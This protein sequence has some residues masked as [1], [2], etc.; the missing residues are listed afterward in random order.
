MKSFSKSFV[1]IFVVAIMLVMAL[2]VFAAGIPTGN[3]QIVVKPGNGGTV[4][5]RELVAVQLMSYTKEGEGQ[6]SY[7][8]SDAQAAVLK[9]AMKATTITEINTIADDADKATVLATLADWMTPQPPKTAP[10]SADISIL[11]TKVLAD[12]AGVATLPQRTLTVDG[13]NQKIENV[14]S[15][16]YIIWDKTSKDKFTPVSFVLHSEETKEVTV[17]GSDD[18]G[19][20]LK[21][22]VVSVAGTAGE[23]TVSGGETV[24]FKITATLPDT[25]PYKTY[26]FNILDQMG[27]GLTL[28]KGSIVVKVKGDTLT[29]NDNA[30][31]D[32]TKEYKVTYDVEKTIA[33]GAQKMTFVVEL[34]NATQYGK[35]GEV[36]VTYSAT[37]GNNLDNAKTTNKSYIEH[38][39]KPG[40]NGE[41]EPPV[42]TGDKD[43]TTTT[44]LPSTELKIRKVDGK[45]ANL[46]GAKFTLK[47][48]RVVK[49]YTT[50]SEYVKQGDTAPQGG[51]KAGTDVYYKLKNGTFT[52]TA[53]EE[54]TK[55]QYDN[56]GVD[57]YDLYTIKAV[58]E[59][60]NNVSKE[61]MVGQDGVI[62]F[63]DLGAGTYT[64][65]ETV[66][67][68]EYKKGNDITITI[69]YV[70]TENNP[71]FKYSTDGTEPAIAM[72]QEIKVV[73]TKTSTLPETGG[74]GTT[75][76]YT[77]GGLLAVI[78]LVV[79][80][81]RKR[82]ANAEK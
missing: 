49:T 46:P 48:T 21:K 61:V 67:P 14:Q 73:N 40:D 6:Y 54:K 76:F 63:K 26:V 37:V 77:L 3:S 13:D 52:K 42:I 29:K 70:G 65:N 17:K 36:E 22:E 57:K 16:Y 59:A 8:I 31:A 4:K 43:G 81:S 25:T 28:N 56:N 45:G 60:T 5:D 66:A 53:P 68:A 2:P 18:Q 20:N 69:K 38:S 34:V 39:G 62:S 75:I 27:E 78:A 50:G 44:T 15:G 79:L 33:G 55:D 23:K 64:L 24:D 82:M 47:G 10:S 74:I 35:G 32:S 11:V 41:G 12:A 9:K 80:V 19:I 72:D 51:E 7:T 58:N 1:A 71:E 30:T